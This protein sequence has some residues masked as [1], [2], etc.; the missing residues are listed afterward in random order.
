MRLVR[1]TIALHRRRDAPLALGL[2]LRLPHPRGGLDGGRGAGLHPG[3]RLRLRRAGAGGRACPSTRS[4]PG[5]AS[6]STPTS[7]SSRRSPSTA[8]PGASGPAGC[9]SATARQSPAARA[10]AV[11]HPDRRRVAH[12]PAARGE[13]R[14]HGHRGAGRRAGRHAEPAHQLHGRGAWPCPPRRRPA[15]PC[16]PSRCSPT[17]PT[18]PTS[19]IRSAELVLRRG[20]HRRD[21]APGRGDL[22]PPRRARRAVRCSRA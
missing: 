16:A 20:A 19:P 10:A 6:S 18:W 7:T 4:R 3:Q 1:D 14:A 21:R 11:P 12:R 13:H 5:S 8:P 22:R 17:R 2:D 15:S 9:R